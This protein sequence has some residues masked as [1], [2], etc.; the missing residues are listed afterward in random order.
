[1]RKARRDPSRSLIELLAN[2]LIDH[3]LREKLFIDQAAVARRFDLPFEEAEALKSLD[4]E[5]FERAA[6]TVRWN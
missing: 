6:A 3:E 4:R 2:A 1:M 5:A